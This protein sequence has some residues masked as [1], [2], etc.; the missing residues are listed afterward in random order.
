MYFIKGSRLVT[1]PILFLHDGTIQISFVYTSVPYAACLTRCNLPS[2]T[3]TAKPMTLANRS[4]GPYLTYYRTV[5]SFSTDG[6][7][8]VHATTS[9]WQSKCPTFMRHGGSPYINGNFWILSHDHRLVVRP[10]FPSPVGLLSQ[11]IPTTG[12]YS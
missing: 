7:I 2:Y 3:I 5:N 1:E 9:Y 4:P 6:P 12:S 11:F 10:L 8:E